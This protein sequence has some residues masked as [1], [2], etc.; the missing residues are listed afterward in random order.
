MHRGEN[1]ALKVSEVCWQLLEIIIAAI[2]MD[3][4][5]LVMCVMREEKKKKKVSH[6]AATK[7]GEFPQ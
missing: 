2:R 5:R 6:S 4:S 1:A 3:H 7:L